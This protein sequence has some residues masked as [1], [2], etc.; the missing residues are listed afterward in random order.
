MFFKKQ[1]P[2]TGG[3]KFL[4]WFVHL[5]VLAIL[6]VALLFAYV[7][8]QPCGAIDK[9]FFYCNF[10]P[11]TGWDIAGTIL[12]ILGGIGLSGIWVLVTGT[13]DQEEGK[14]LMWGSFIA[15]LGGGLLTLL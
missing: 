7:W 8:E 15:A 1:E 9:E 5:G 3:E 14:P 13:I 11:T 6:V 2:E 10:H 4:R 12:F